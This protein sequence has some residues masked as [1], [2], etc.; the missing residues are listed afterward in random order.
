MSPKKIDHRRNYVIMLDTETANTITE[1][2]NGKKKLDMSSV[3]AYDIGWIIA[4][5]RGNVYE[6]RSYINADIFYHESALMKSAYYA[7][8]IPM[9]ERQLRTGERVLST[10]WNIRKQLLSDLK[11]YKCNIFVAHNAKFDLRSL[12][13]TIKWRSKSKYRYFLPYGMEIWDTQRMAQSVITKTNSYRAFCRENGILTPTGRIPSSAEALY[14][15]ITKNV[16]FSESHT[17]LEDC[18]IQLEIMK[19]CFRKK[20][21]MKKH[22]FNKKE[23]RLTGLSSCPFNKKAIE[24]FKN[25]KKP[26]DNR[27]ALC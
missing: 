20:K 23:K 26:V 10:T 14:K 21:A 7:E 2:K 12:N 17:G 6:K 18:E 27:L 11:E 24:N 22:A 3:L 9:Y 5:T 13:N 25:K 15:F 16:N 19:F 1:E 8:K 4:D